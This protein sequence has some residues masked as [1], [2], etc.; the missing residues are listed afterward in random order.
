M[1]VSITPALEAFVREQV[2]GGRYGNASEV[3]RAALRLLAEREEARAAALA[4]VRAL[5]EEGLASGPAEPWSAEEFLAEMHAKA[6]IAA[7]A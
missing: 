6:G 2:A 4:K 1:N 5:V 7:E 3:V